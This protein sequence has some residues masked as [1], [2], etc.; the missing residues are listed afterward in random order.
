[1]S[2]KK[3]LLLFLSS[4]LLL[5]AGNSWAS[6]RADVAWKLID[7]GALLIDVRTPEEYQVQHL[8]NSVNLPLSTVPT[9]F[10]NIDKNRLVVV[11]CRSGN[12]SGQ[13]L[14]YLRQK[15][16]TKVFNGGGLNEMLAA[17]FN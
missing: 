7:E 12:R 16:F 17:K 3:P 10:N 15:G 14:N 9:A 13:A 5:C 4:L 6:D 2:I 8:E 11:Y 1:V